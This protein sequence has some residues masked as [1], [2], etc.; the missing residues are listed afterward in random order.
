MCDANQSNVEEFILLGFPNMSMVKIQFFFSILSLYVIIVSMNTLL[1][2]LV[3]K[4][5]QLELPMFFFLQNL[6]LA[7]IFLTT[8]TVP[9]M[10][11]VILWE[12]VTISFSECVAQFYFHSVAGIV[13][14]FLLTVM[15]YDRYV[16]IH[17]PLRYVSIMDLKHRLH[18]ALWCWLLGFLV[19]AMEMFFIWN[20]KFC[21]LN[22]IDFFFCDFA[23]LLELSTSDTSMVILE[24][25]IFSIPVII[26]PFVFIIVTY[27]LIINT[28]LKISS[29]SGKKKAFSTCSSHLIIVCI[30]YGTLIVV[31]VVP[32]NGTHV[33]K[34]MSLLYILVTPLFN[35]IIYSLR[36][37]EIKSEILKI[38]KREK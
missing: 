4:S 37:H 9:K 30:Y 35:P 11:Q 38:I 8:N 17:N 19:M 2:V 7:D 3:A 26:L 15:S 29:M 25:F 6:S 34:F 32:S 1:V 33:N 23:P 22:T 14:C 12:A 5:R 27:I 36:N 10:L 28:V 24:D 21:G 16:A 31:Y 20:L 18:L 13:E